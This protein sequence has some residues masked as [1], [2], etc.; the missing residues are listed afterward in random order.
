MA[1]IRKLKK[2]VNQLAAAI[3]EAAIGEQP[4]MT[5]RAVRTRRKV[6]SR[7]VVVIKKK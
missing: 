3:L 6:R 2:D 1:K 4:S 5:A 7:H